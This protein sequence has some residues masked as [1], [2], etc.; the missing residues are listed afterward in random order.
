[1]CEYVLVYDFFYFDVEKSPHFHKIKT[2]FWNL[3]FL[4]S[5]NS[6]KKMIKISTKLFKK[7]KELLWPK[8]VILMSH[9]FCD[10]VTQN[11]K[12]RFSNWVSWSVLKRVSL[13]LHTYIK[14]LEMFLRTTKLCILRQIFEIAMINLCAVKCNEQTKT[15]RLNI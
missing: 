9:H 15:M 5:K 10:Q 11:S 6:A 8:C 13:A 12:N 14:C 2:V 1:M 7:K 4:A 3:L